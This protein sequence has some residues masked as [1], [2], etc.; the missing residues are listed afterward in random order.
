MIIKVQYE[1]RDYTYE[2][3]AE[4]VLRFLDITQDQLEAACKKAIIET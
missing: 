1:D 2:I 3:P 4:K